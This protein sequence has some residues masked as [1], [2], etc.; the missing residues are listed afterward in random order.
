[1]LCVDKLIKTKEVVLHGDM[2]FDLLNNWIAR[3]PLGNMAPRD[4]KFI[5]N[6]IKQALLHPAFQ[7]IKGNKEFQKILYQLLKDDIDKG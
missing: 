4:K 2:Y 5:Q 7:E 1:M 6:N 3:L